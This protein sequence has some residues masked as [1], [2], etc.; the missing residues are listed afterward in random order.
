VSTRVCHVISTTMPYRCACV[1]AGVHNTEQL[2]ALSVSAYTVYTLF[3]TG[4]DRNLVISE[5]KNVRN[6]KW[7]SA[8]ANFAVTRQ[9]L[10]LKH[11]YHQMCY[12][13]QSYSISITSMVNVGLQEATVSCTAYERLMSPS[14]PPSQRRHCHAM[15]DLF[16]GKCKHFRVAINTPLSQ[17]I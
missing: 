17:L 10:L 9:V 8:L 2:H 12:S 14:S 1:L 13:T 15:F 7:I 5:I 11:S 3:S 6:L 4:K 16:H